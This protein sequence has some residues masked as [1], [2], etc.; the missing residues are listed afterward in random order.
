MKDF[1]KNHA[2]LVL[3][4]LSSFAVLVISSY[5]SVTM[6]KTVSMMQESLQN[7]LLT[8]AMACA[9]MVSAEE[10]ERY[11]TVADTQ[12]PEYA[13]LREKLI[14]FAKRF[15]V[16]YAYYWRDNGDERLQYIVDNDM[17]PDTQV[18]P[19]SF[20]P[21]EAFA[22]A[23]LTGKPTAT[24]FEQYTPT[25]D[26]LLSAWAPVYDSAGVI[27]AIAG[28]DMS[29]E[30]IL[31]Q[32]DATVNR[33]RIQ[34]VSL[35]LSIGC[36]VIMFLL[37]RQK[38]KLLSVFNANLQQMVEE[39]TQKTLTLHET[40][41]RYLSDEIVK[42]LLESPQGLALGGKK[43]IITIMMADLR[44]FTS[45]SEQMQVEDAVTMLNNYFSRMV[46]VIHKYNGTVIEY[47]GDGILAIF[48][49]P[50]SYQNYTDSA[51]ACAME[52]Q[53]AMEEVNSWNAAHSF[54]Q[55]EMGIGI[56]SGETIVGNIGSPKVMKYN[57]IGSNVN[58]ASRIESYSTG[59][60]VLISESS[61]RQVHA[62]LG[63]VQTIDIA[64]KGVEKVVKVYQVNSIGEPFR[65]ALK[66]SSIPLRMLTRPISVSCFCIEGKHVNDNALKYYIVSISAK[67]AIVI[68][69][70]GEPVLAVFDNVKL[71]DA[72]GSA[73]FAKVIRK[74]DKNLILLQFTTDAKTFVKGVLSEEL[75]T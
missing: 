57:V 67:Q 8:S 30:A 15:N 54:P 14:D 66:H 36:S 43:Q 37:Y 60:Q 44:G 28:V 3:F 27:R 25:W 2:V 70:K 1:I 32:R 61:Y 55:L 74:N 58:L 72:K 51:V 39:E 69:R 38:I 64:P 22:Y 59:G 56:N 10:L 49:A 52:M 24:D 65:L 20:Y 5:A 16:L 34:I 42:D 73:V 26:G 21:L 18:G 46:E 62:E 50:V 7:H 35:V 41:G 12:V 4:F 48:G 40:F 31:F 47:L 11:Y 75:R 63:I 17:D 19:A 6:S 68:A 33:Q 45:V 53:L 71:I 23:A 13:A 9:Q 29:D